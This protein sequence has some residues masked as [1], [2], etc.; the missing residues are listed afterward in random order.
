M[1]SYQFGILKELRQSIPHPTRP[2]LQVTASI[3]FNSARI[4]SK[5]I[6]LD[7]GRL[8]GHSHDQLGR[9][10]GKCL[11][12]AVITNETCIYANGVKEQDSIINDNCPCKSTAYVIPSILKTNDIV[13]ILICFHPQF[14]ILG[15]PDGSSMIKLYRKRPIK[16]EVWRLI[17]DLEILKIYTYL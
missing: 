8:G 11:E 9:L 14:D 10:R 12:S 15:N 6:V 1:Q 13:G 16:T 2:I 7:N 17:C 5:P 3:K 4:N